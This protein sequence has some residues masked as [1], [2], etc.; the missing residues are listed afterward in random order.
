MVVKLAMMVVASEDVFPCSRIIERVSE[1][2][3]RNKRLYI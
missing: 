2:M 1:V 3:A